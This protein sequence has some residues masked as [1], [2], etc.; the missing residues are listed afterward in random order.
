MKRPLFSVITITKNSGILFERTAKSIASQTFSDFE[1]IVVDGSTC[2]ESVNVIDRNI[3]VGV[4]LI[5]GL[6]RNISD[7]W[8]LGIKCS[9]GYF[10]LILNSGDT[11]AP[12][13]LELC[14]R[15]RDSNDIIL[16]GSAT[17]VDDVGKEHFLLTPKI[18]ALWRGMHIPHN[19]MCVPFEFYE[20]YGLYSEIDHAMD[21]EWVYRVFN[22]RGGS[23]FLALPGRSHGTYLLGGHSDKNYIQGLLKSHHI[24]SSYGMNKVLSFLLLVIYAANYFLRLA[25]K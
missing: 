22:S 17:T 20:K 11:Y 9:I 7:A 1:W 5:R 13:F 3:L 23:C 14:S 24:R 18:N 16:C 15:Y 4:K 2:R 8:N 19:W 12:T 10:I 25:F 6:D 21:Y